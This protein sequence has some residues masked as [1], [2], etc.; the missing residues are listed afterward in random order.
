MRKKLTG[1]FAVIACLALLT[2]CAGNASSEVQEIPEETQNSLYSLTESTIQSMDEVVKSGLIEEQQSNAVIYAGLQSWETAVEELGAVDFTVDADGN[3]LADC[4]AEKSITVDDEGNYIASDITAVLAH[5]RHMYKMEDDEVAVVG[6]DSIAFY[7]TDGEPIG[8]QLETVTWDV[9]AAEKGGYPHFMIKEIMEQPEAVRNTF[10][11]RITEDGTVKLDDIDL[12]DDMIRGFHKINIVGC[13]SAYHV[14]LVARYVIEQLARIPVEVD[15][16]SEFRYRYP[17]VDEHTLTIVIS[18]SGETADSLEALREAKRLG[19]RTLS[20]VNVVGSS[21][22]TESDDVL[23]TWAGPEISVA[24]TKAYSTQLIVM[25]LLAI[26]FALATGALSPSAAAEILAE[27]EK[28]P[29]KIEKIFEQTDKIERIAESFTFLHH[30]YFIGRNIDYAVGLE[31]SLK[32]KE[33]SYIHSEAY[34][35]GELKHGTISLIEP[36]TQ[37]VALCGCERLVDKTVSN[38][39]EL[40]ARGAHVLGIAVE[41]NTDVQNIA[42]KVI[43]IPETLPVLQPSLEIVPMQLLGY[44]TAVA[45]KCDVDQPRNLAKSVTVE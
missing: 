11:P 20:V 23:Y 6:K 39:K 16:A 44:Y 26:R 35:G 32:L 3:G 4:F 8:K 27:M 40:M 2:A 1:L 29:G 12:T 30:A 43:Y 42:D 36:G 17:L 28:L 15:L 33:V 34:A 14:G 21:I 22:A 31:A 5:T 19:S 45:R 13:G 25:D 9:S 7:N 41:G 38:A 18:Q 24:T 10:S 37:V